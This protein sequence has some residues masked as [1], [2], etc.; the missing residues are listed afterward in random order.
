MENGSQHESD[1][2]DQAIDFEDVTNLFERA[3]AGIVVFICT[4]W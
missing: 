1:L 4:R 3:A 2:P